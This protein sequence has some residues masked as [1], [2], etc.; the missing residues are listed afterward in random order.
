MYLGD[1]HIAHAP[2]KVFALRIYLD[3]KYQ[4]IVRECAEA[5]RTV[6]PSNKVGVV[7]HLHENVDKVQSYSR[8]WPCLFPQHG[9]GMKHTRPINLS[10]WQQAIVDRHTE[11]L[12]RGLIHSDGCRSINTI[13]HPKK[14]CVYPRYLFSNRSDDILGIFCRACDQLGIDWRVMNPWNISVARRESI[15]RLDEFIGPK[16]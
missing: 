14:T 13:K 1:G 5:M 6:M 2:R 3:R 9:P 10:N 16:R 12:L 15:A 11:A 4:G 8:Q 7:R